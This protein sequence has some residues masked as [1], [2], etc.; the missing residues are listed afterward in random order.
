MGLGNFSVLGMASLGFSE[1]YSFETILQGGR[2]PTRLLQNRD[3][4]R[5]TLRKEMKETDEA[6][7]SFEC[8]GDI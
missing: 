2:S 1:F 5:R 4:Q 6:E 8:E 3:C 7:S